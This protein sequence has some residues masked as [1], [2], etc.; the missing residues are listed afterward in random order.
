MSE[1]S[2]YF[3]PL[4]RP[5]T[6]KVVELT[7]PLGQFYSTAAGSRLLISDFRVSDFW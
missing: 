6:R 7:S 5:S 1:V 3:L 2:A 4:I